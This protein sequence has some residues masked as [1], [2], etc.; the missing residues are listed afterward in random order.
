MFKFSFIL[1]FIIALSSCVHGTV[2]YTGAIFTKKLESSEQIIKQR[3]KEAQSLDL[4]AKERY[5]Y[6]R[7]LTKFILEPNLVKR[8]HLTNSNVSE[9]HI[10]ESLLFL[11]CL[12]LRY[13]VTQEAKY[14]ETAHKIIQGLYFLENLDGFNGY[15]PR[16]V[17]KKGDNFMPSKEQIATNSYSLLAF[18]YLLAYQNFDN[19]KIKNMLTKHLT[20]IT[21]YILEH[22]LELV[23]PDGSKVEF[24]KFNAKFDPSK[25]LTGLAFFETANVIVRNDQIKATLQDK[26]ENLYRKKYRKKNKITYLRLFGF[27]D[28]ASTSSNWLNYIK[29]YTAIKA[30][31]HPIYKKMFSKLYHNL[32]KEENIFY[33]LLYYDIYPTALSQLHYSKQ[34]LASFPLELNNNEI[35]NSGRATVKTTKFTNI[36]K[37]K[38]WLETSKPL[39]IYARPIIYHEWKR[40][41]FRVNGNIGANGNVEFSGLD[42]LLAYSIYEKILKFTQYEA[43]SHY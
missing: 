4:P 30:T 42:F 1:I 32:A 5:F 40:N 25:Q 35:I 16:Y 13:Q 36:I 31:N 33:D 41:Q 22:N 12:A 26:L 3:E 43:N 23:E 6:E 9:A 15:L 37:N 38:R 29:L 18:A 20:I 8:Y 11:A 28:L 10:D 19:E 24:G 27:W 7:F 17:I 34:I 14:Q 39:P 21:K 2:E